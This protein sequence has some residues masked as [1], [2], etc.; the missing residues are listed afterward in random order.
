M[1]VSNF[2]KQY[3]IP[4]TLFYFAILAWASQPFIIDDAY[5]SLR[6][7]VHLV[8]YGTPY[9]NLNQ[10]VY[11]VTNPLWVYLTALLYYFGIKAT[12]AVFILGFVFLYLSYISFIQLIFKHTSSFIVSLIGGSLFISNPLV[13]GVGLSGMETPLFLFLIIQTFLQFHNKN[14][15]LAW[16]LAGISLFVRLDGILIGAAL[17]VVL[18][19]NKAPLKSYLGMLLGFVLITLY[20]VFGST[21]YDQAIPNS[22]GRKLLLSEYLSFQHFSSITVNLYRVIKGII[23]NTAYTLLP[24]PHIIVLLLLFVKKPKIKNLLISPSYFYTFILISSMALLSTNVINYYWYYI[25]PLVGFYIWA[26]KSL[27]TLYH[28]KI[29]LTQWASISILL[30]G[31]FLTYKYNAHFRTKYYWQ[32]REKSYIAIGKW[33]AE[34][35]PLHSKL[36]TNEIGTIAFY[37]RSDIEILDTYG[38]SRLK[39]DRGIDVFTYIENYMPEAIAYK[40]TFKVWQPMPLELKEKYHWL[41]DNR[42]YLAIRKDVWEQIEVKKPVPI[43]HYY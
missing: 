25:P 16:V 7:A 19:F 42:V 32:P 13:L 22:V 6:C 15:V 41:K 12:T 24:L 39:K 38:L 34:Y 2:L 4:V 18:L 5:I 23:G 30:I 3:Y 36:A 31:I 37:T 35:L 8:D 33:T 21:V 27:L 11:T 40:E 29:N 14:Y 26:S 9:F 10:N 1:T 20:L 28:K 43:S 17:F